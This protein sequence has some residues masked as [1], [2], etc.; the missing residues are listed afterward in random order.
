MTDRRR[1]WRDCE[2]VALDFETSGLDMR[3]A[4]PL[5]VGWV[6]I[7][8]GRIV[9]A[10]AGY[11]RIRL[12]GDVGSQSVPTHQLLPQDLE[13]APS[14]MEVAAQLE[15]LLRG[16]T[17]LAHAADIE[18]RLLRRCGI[19]AR[20]RLAL[21]T[22]CLAR[23]LDR[24]SDVSTAQRYNLTDLARRHGVPAHRPHHAFGDAL[25]TASLFLALVAGLEGHG[26][27]RLGALRRL[28][29]TR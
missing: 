14:I 21:D 8:H 16:R 9:L 26:V 28:S 3:H 24:L 27:E 25:T 11:T 7:R 17:L 10:D 4:R 2:F 13:D 5:S 15:D 22:L 6:V 23:S 20:R 19:A 29:R 12:W 18:V 1:H